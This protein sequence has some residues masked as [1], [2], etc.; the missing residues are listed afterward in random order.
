L[1]KAVKFIPFALIL[2]VYISA[3]FIDV[4]DVDSAQYASMAKE[5]I[6]RDSY[7]E[8][9]DQGRNYLD[10]PPLLFWLSAASYHIFGISNA[11]F[12]LPSMLFALLGILSVYGMAK[13]YYSKTE[14]YWAAIIL[15]STQAFFLMV[16]D[17]RTDLILTGAVIFAVW[18]LAEYLEKKKWQNFAL[19]FIGIGLAMLAKGPI[20][21]VLPGVAFAIHLLLLRDWKNILRWQWLMGLPIIALVLLPMCIGLYNQYDANPNVIVNGHKGESGLLFYFWTQSFGRITG[22]NVWNNNPGPFFLTESTLWAFM[23]WTVFLLAAW[24]SGW[25]KIIKAKFRIAKGQE[26]ITL[27]AFTF[28]LL[29]LSKSSYQLPHYIFVAYPFAAIFTAR[30]VICVLQDG[31]PWAKNILKISQLVILALVW[32]LAG[33]LLFYVFKPENVFILIVVGMGLIMSLYYIS[34]NYSKVTSVLQVSFVTICIFNLVMNLHFYPQLM[35]YQSFSV[36]GKYIA[37]KAKQENIS[38]KNFFIFPIG[39]AH[40]LDFY[41]GFNVKNVWSEQYFTRYQNGDTVWVFTNDEGK[42]RLSVLPYTITEEL[43]MPFYKPAELRPAFLNP[44]T[45]QSTFRNHY[46]MRVII[47]DQ[48]KADFSPYKIQRD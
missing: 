5:M 25:F 13:L 43:Y 23:P 30:W 28:A 46:I 17:V 31:F 18:Q 32:A 1:K 37:Q 41:T 11:A 27:G 38:Q 34:K 6:D 44:A 42:E 48:E 9:T 35:R 45:R 33:I 4:M 20:G 26:A 39:S 16:N 3:L 24:V 40:S 29:A 15:G 8:I 10:K 19:G 47:K 7:L 14:A 36:A 21:L 22:E 2:I 12:K